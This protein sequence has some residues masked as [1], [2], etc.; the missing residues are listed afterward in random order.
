MLKVLLKKQLAEAFKS[1]FY[2]AKKNKMRSK[3]AIIGWFVFFI[4]I[5]AGVLCGT[6]TYLALSL[7]DPLAQAGMN[8]L[9]YL[10]LSGI[11]I[12]L[13]AFGSVFNTYAGLYLG[14]DNDLLLSLPIPART[15]ITARLMNVYLMGT[16]YAST[17]LL[18]AL[19]V[20]WA[21]A[22]VT[23]ARIVCGLLLFLIVTVIVL[24]LSCILGWVV[25]KISLKLKNKSFVTVLLSLL[26]IG[27]Y[28][29]IYFKANDLIKDIILR[30]SVYGEKVRGA[31]YGL[32]LFGRIGEGAWLP[33]LLF[34]A[35]TAAGFVLTWLVLSRSFL[36][37]ATAG[38]STKAARHTEKRTKEKSVF[39]ALLGKEFAR[40]TSN[41]NYMLNCGFGIL[42]IPVAGVLLLFKG[43]MLCTLIGT[44]LSGR[45]GS[46]AVLLC[47]MLCALSSMNDMAAP[48]ISLEG[49]SLWIPQSLPVSPGAVLRAKAMM[50]LIL[51]EVPLLFAAV[52]AA[53]IVPA[54]PAVKVLVAAVPLIYTAFS[55]LFGTAIGVRMPLLT[56]TNDLVP[57]KQSGAVMIALF[58]GWIVSAALAG[59]Y[60]LIGYKIG[61][62][63]YLAV[64][65][66][67]LAAAAAVTLRW[68]NRTGSRLF[69]ELG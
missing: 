38:G 19:I 1:Y 28:Y 42:L 24:L 5:M 48:S 18:P 54:G 67:L 21:V 27:G 39:G 46:A 56:W 55:A 16:M 68:L 11:A 64:W 49:K 4:V 31:A 13:G 59:L 36:N 52:C 26:F 20:N 65:A 32:Y 9:Y 69:A 22:G 2:D 10:I 30:A 3:G 50:H 15:I 62:L 41:A 43:D 63:V 25:A 66:V 47:T 45:P 53:V 14:K 12:A 35:V 23:A 29:F 60:L 17:V 44:M 40:F 57:I 51:T 58:G 61:A 33:A 7:C 34:A 8:W 37:I 6:F